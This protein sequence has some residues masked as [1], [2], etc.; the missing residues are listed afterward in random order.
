MAHPNQQRAEINFN[1]GQFS[2]SLGTLQSIGLEAQSAFN[3]T[4]TATTPTGLF[5]PGAEGTWNGSYSWF[6]EVGI[7]WSGPGLDISLTRS[8]EKHTSYSSTVFP[9][10]LSETTGNQTIGGTGSV[11][12]ASLGDWVGGGTV[13]LQLAVQFIGFHPLLVPRQPTDGG[14]FVTSVNQVD[15]AQMN[16]LSISQ[17]NLVYNYLP[18]P[19]PTALPLSALA[20]SLICLRR[21]R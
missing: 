14:F 12:A 9:I 15:N 3:L 4:S 8:F 21:C 18:I 16:L 13:N 7:A 10:P 17:L 20:L 1:I 11:S 5:V 19:E 6:A 2:P